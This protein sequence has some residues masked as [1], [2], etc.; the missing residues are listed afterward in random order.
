MIRALTF[1][2][3]FILIHPLYRF[4]EKDLSD[5]LAAFLTQSYGFG[6]RAKGTTLQ[7]LN[8]KCFIGD[9]QKKTFI[10][11]VQSKDLAE[12]ALKEKLQSITES[13]RALLIEISSKTAKSTKNIEKEIQ[14]LKESLNVAAIRDAEMK[15]SINLILNHLR[16]FFCFFKKIGLFFFVN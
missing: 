9:F 7:C 14:N 13:E 6:N 16:F 12:R 1:Y 5:R 10:S 3:Y 4:L 2:F 8:L 15:D 11:Q